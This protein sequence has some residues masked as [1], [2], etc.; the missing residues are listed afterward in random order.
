M[1]HP[2]LGLLI[3][4]NNL[5]SQVP[6]SAE[7]VEA[8]RVAMETVGFTVKCY[9]DCNVQIHKTNVFHGVGIILSY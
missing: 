2:Q 4:I 6:E 9:D 8:L 5:R 1:V 3:I 7:D